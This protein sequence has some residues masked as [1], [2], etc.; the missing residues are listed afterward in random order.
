MAGQP[1][2]PDVARARFAAFVQRALERARARGLTDREIQRRSSV[3]TSTFHRWRKA[4]GKEMP[5]IAKVQ[6]FC[7]AVDAD[8][9]EALD[10]LGMG[11]K[12]RPAPTPPPPMPEDVLTI[13]R[14][15]ADPNVS[16]SQKLAIRSVLQMLAAQL[17]D[18]PAAEP[19]SGPVAADA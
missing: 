17:D 5:E 14:K 8:F 15:L 18:R 7:R 10:A 13:L 6:A 16:E 9:A 19:P 3:A 2:S 1:L 4:E 12:G 11:E